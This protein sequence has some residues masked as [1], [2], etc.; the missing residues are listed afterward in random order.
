MTSGLRLRPLDDA[1]VSQLARELRLLPTTA[2]CLV[3]RG[4]DVTAL[5]SRRSYD[6][7]GQYAAREVLDGVTVR[8]LP[9]L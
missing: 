1:L 8:R 4:H 5:C 9:A 3:A 2:R 7:G 6:G